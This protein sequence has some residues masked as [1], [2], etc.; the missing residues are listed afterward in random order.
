MVTPASRVMSPIVAV[1]CT[2]ALALGAL[3]GGVTWKV[4]VGAVPGATEVNSVGP[5]ATAVQ[6]CGSCS[7]SWTSGRV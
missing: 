4:A 6:P 5:A 7:A 3:L 2:T 1:A